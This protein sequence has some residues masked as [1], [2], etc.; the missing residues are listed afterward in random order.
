MLI[1]DIR[2]K[3]YTESREK[4]RFE[5]AFVRRK[6]RKYLEMFTQLSHREESK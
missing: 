1:Q 5:C 4:N 3:Y 2:T 6:E